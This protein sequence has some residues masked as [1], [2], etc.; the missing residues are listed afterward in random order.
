M[1]TR[2]ARRRPLTSA[3]QGVLRR[4]QDAVAALTQNV[5]LFVAQPGKALRESPTWLANRL[6]RV[7]VLLMVAWIFALNQ[8]EITAFNKSIIACDWSLWEDWVRYKPL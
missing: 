2:T 1:V 3:L 4:C 8:N 5:S 7:E 6:I